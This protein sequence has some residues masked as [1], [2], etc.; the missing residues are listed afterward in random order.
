MNY[1]LLLTTHKHPEDAGRVM[2]EM[3]ATTQGMNREILVIGHEESD[4]PVGEDLPTFRF[5][6]QPEKGCAK[7]IWYGA[8]HC[9]GDWFV[10]LCD[11]HEYPVRDWLERADRIR[12]IAVA[13]PIKVIKFNAGTGHKECAS[14]GMA[15]TKWYKDHYP[16]P[17]FEHYGWDNEIQE[18]AIKEG[19][20]YYAKD[21]LIKDTVVSGR[22]NWEVKKRDWDRWQQ[23]RKM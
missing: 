1:T 11:D 6:T 18:W 16:E 9:W 12:T 17:V 21:I 7:S 3:E 22:I 14:I 10:W 5:M 13:K 19:V 23:R 2:K 15:E 20:F 4:R 8:H